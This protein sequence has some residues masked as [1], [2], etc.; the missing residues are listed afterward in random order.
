MIKKNALP[1]GGTSSIVNTQ[2]TSLRSVTEGLW[3]D[4]YSRFYFFFFKHTCQSAQHGGEQSLPVQCLSEGRQ[5]TWAQQ[6]AHNTCR[7][8]LSSFSLQSLFLVLF[9]FF[10]A[11][12]ETKGKE[13]INRNFHRTGPSEVCLA[14]LSGPRQA[15]SSRRIPTHGRPTVDEV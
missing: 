11:L 6:H 13:Q 7:T 5:H 15:E 3:G 9:F 12:M 4:G 10:L 2:H 8:G 1:T 14:H